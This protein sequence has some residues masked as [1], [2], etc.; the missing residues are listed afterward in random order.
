MIVIP[1]ID[2]LTWPGLQIRGLVPISSAVGIIAF[3]AVAVPMGEAPPRSPGSVPALLTNQSNQSGSNTKPDSVSVGSSAG[4]ESLKPSSELQELQSKPI[5][6]TSGREGIQRALNS[7]WIESACYSNLALIEVAR[8]LE[9]ETMRQDPHH[10]G[11]SFVADPG[12]GWDSPSAAQVKI[13]IVPAL[14]RLRLSEL[15]EAMLKTAERPIKF[16]IEDQGVAFSLR[17]S[18]ASGDESAP[19]YTRVFRVDTNRFFGYLARHFGVQK[20]II[21]PRNIEGPDGV[22]STNDIPNIVVA[23][24][25]Q[26]GDRDTATEMQA[27]VAIR[28]FLVESGLDLTNPGK[29][30]FYTYGEGTLLIRATLL[31]IDR[32]QRTLE[33]LGVRP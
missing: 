20:I 23:N 28:R 1:R 4:G 12:N 19:L 25:T 8:S 15:L 22:Q 30:F 11:I 14:K 16:S 18:A 17:R 31:E 32:F 29:S 2:R 33:M 3:A 5:W 27:I 7:I 26:N 10:F 13:R 21:P 24:V 9:Q 6:P